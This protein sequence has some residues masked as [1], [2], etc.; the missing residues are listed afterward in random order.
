MAAQYETWLQEVGSALRSINMPMEEWQNAWKFDFQREYSIGT[1]PGDAAAKANRFWWFQQ[2]KAFGQGCSKTP[3]CW[4]PA[5]HERA[6]EP[7]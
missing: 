2:N 6:C 5:G 3:N 7:L 4:L 1:P